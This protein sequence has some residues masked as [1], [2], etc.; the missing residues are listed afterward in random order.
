[1]HL[2]GKHQTTD[3]GF[4][5]GLKLSGARSQLRLSATSNWLRVLFLKGEAAVALGNGTGSTVDVD[6]N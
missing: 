2:T 5:F 6:A 4:F 3:C 1:M